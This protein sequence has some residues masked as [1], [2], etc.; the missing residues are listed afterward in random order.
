MVHNTKLIFINISL[1]YFHNMDEYAV[2]FKQIQVPFHFIQVFIT[3]EVL[4]YTTQNTSKQSA[5][6]FA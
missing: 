6:E 4:G 3:H 5:L 2:F 1:L